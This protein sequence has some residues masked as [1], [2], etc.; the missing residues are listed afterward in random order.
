L[1]ETGV[2]MG[3]NRF[4]LCLAG[5]FM[6]SARL[7]QAEFARREK[8]NPST[9]SRWVKAGRIPVEPDG[10][11]DPEK[12]RRAREATESPLP[13]HQAR[14]AQIEE[15]K[16][17]PGVNGSTAEIGAALKLETWKLQRAK[18]EMAALE[19]DVKAG[20]LVERANVNFVLDD[21]C[22]MQR[23]LL[24]ALPRRVAGPLAAHQSDP[25]AIRQTLDEAVRELLAEFSEYL[26]RRAAEG[27]L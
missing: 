22:A 4:F 6:V 2:E 5:V 16:Q 11:I 14:K 19:V 26:A 12:A 9:V 24:E 17:T 21:F 13:H 15:Q 25:Q 27:K 8:V 3:G 10:R 23:R 7:S 1:V 18:A 20:L